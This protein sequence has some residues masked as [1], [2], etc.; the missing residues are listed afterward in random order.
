[1]LRIN[2]IALGMLAYTG[3]WLTSTGVAY[4]TETNLFKQYR[5]YP[6][7]MATSATS[8]NAGIGVNATV[9]VNPSID[10]SDSASVDAS[11]SI[12][13]RTAITTL[14]NTTPT[15]IGQTIDTMP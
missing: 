15:A 4:A 6:I 7:S 14:M 5:N 1:M 13:A 10:V 3:L 2:N 12:S 11:T 9:G 8:V